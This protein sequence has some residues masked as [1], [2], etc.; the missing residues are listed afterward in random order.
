MDLETQ[1]WKPF[2]L[3][4]IDVQN[5]FWSGD[6]TQHFPQF[7]ENIVQLLNFCRTVGIEV[8]HIR[9]I[10]KPDM[11][12][13]MVRYKLR[14]RIPC[15]E[16]TVGAEVAPFA[17]ALPGEKVVIKHSFDGFLAPELLPYLQQTGKRFLLVAGLV[18]STCVLFTT[19]SGMQNGFLT[20]IVEDCCADEPSWHEH[21][22]DTYQFIFK[23][24]QLALLSSDYEKWL[25]DLCTLAT[26]EESISAGIHGTVEK[27]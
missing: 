25:A 26:I 3:L 22:L 15:V 9:A 21:T 14:K 7:P 20:A 2:A 4:L 27:S 10:F 8:I 18:T 13:W 16:G 11:S 12:D 17:Q 23:R 24:T 19:V 5:D 6:F 1:K